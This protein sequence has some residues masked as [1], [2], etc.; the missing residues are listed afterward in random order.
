MFLHIFCM[1]LPWLLRKQLSRRDVCARYQLFYKFINVIPNAE[2][3]DEERR[4]N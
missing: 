4:L 3:V 1:F 2:A